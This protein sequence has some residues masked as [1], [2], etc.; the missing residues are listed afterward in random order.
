MI[1][2]DFSTLKV[3]VDKFK[4]FG[5][6]RGVDLLL[7]QKS[8]LAYLK[9]L[10]TNEI[11]VVGCDFSR[12][13]D[14]KKEKTIE[15]VGAGMVVDDNSPCDPF[16]SGVEVLEFIRNRFPNDADFV[17]LIFLDGDIYDFLR[18]NYN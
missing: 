12:Y 4:P 9:E 10:I 8:A 14:E 18:S 1:K 17:S 2:N 6:F 13:F 7:P 11:L 5:L 15:L 3:I 16:I